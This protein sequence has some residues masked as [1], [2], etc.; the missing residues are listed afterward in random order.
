MAR[1]TTKNADV[2][3]ANEIYNV[4]RE[5]ADQEIA[6][7]KENL[8]R[9]HSVGVMAG[10]VQ[11]YKTMQLLS[12]F[13]TFK[14]IAQIIDS[15]DYKLIPGVTS[16]DSYFEKLGIK[17][18][19]GYNNLKIARTLEAEEVQLLERVG[20]TRRDL[21]GYASLPEEK[22]LE[23][24]EGKVINLE[25]ASRE[26]IR[27][28]I[29][30]VV[31]ETRQT[32]EEADATIKAKDKVLK[33]KETLLNKQAREL[34]KFEKE[35]EAKGLTPDEDAFLQQME[36]FRISFDGYMNRLDPVDAFCEYDEVTP[37]MRAALISALHYM[38][39]EVLAGY[40]TAITTHGNPAMNPEL[41]EDFER[42]EAQ[43]G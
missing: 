3:A 33:D 42:W 36:N 18:S 35:A 38:R 11:A 12:E 29:E 21:L 34:A 5:Q 9:V 14:Q 1:N 37:R 27:D 43:R 7:L 32:R 23:I 30:Q 16:I 15:G 13:L 19:T 25:S 28:L 40:D 10:R 2:E 39:M 6:E 8:G 17:G 20:F 22:R 41:L 24:K 26:E 4:A 31:V